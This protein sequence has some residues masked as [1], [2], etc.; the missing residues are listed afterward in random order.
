MV[1]EN[2]LWLCPRI[3]GLIESDWKWANEARARGIK[4]STFL[5]PAQVP[6][7]MFEGWWL[8]NPDGT[9][10]RLRVDEAAELRVLHGMEA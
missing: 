4:V 7:W 1:I 2:L 10:T 6:V 5:D 3:N 8:L 9:K